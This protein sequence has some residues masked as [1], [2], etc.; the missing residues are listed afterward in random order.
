MPK[1]TRATPAGD[2]RRSLGCPRDTATVTRHLLCP[3]AAPGAGLAFADEGRIGNGLPNGGA[4]IRLAAAA[5]AIV[6][7]VDGAGGPLSWD[8]R[9]AA[10][11]VRVAT[12]AR[13]GPVRVGRAAGETYFAWYA[14]WNACAVSC[15]MATLA[16]S[17]VCLHFMA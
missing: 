4:G 3:L 11:T 1:A 17:V 9:A 8:E 13:D 10:L 12:V 5:G 15:S 16:R 6:D 2:G 7:A 14:S